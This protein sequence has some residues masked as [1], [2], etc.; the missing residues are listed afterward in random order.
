MA[1]AYVSP[2]RSQVF[3]I[4][5]LLHRKVTVRDREYFYDVEENQSFFDSLIESPRIVSL[6]IGPF[7]HTVIVDDIAWE[8]SDAHGTS[9]SFD[10]TL[11]VTL[12][13]VEN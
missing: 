6:Q 12:R 3:D 13:S 5:I 4:P 11:V 9:W 10:G 7:T 1:R 2:Y 8:S